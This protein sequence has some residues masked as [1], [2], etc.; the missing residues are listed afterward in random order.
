MLRD[1]E[2]IHKWMALL[3]EIIFILDIYFLDDYGVSSW[4]SPSA[5]YSSGTGRRNLTLGLK[6]WGSSVYWH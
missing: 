6:I 4:K 2:G 3:G 1:R 5:V